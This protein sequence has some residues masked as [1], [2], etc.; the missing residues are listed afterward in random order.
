MADNNYSMWDK[1]QLLAR[2]SCK[3]L[4]KY[5]A[6]VGSKESTLNTLVNLLKN[7]HNGYHLWKRH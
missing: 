7:V 6:F 2:L 1:G 5:T 3:K 4:A